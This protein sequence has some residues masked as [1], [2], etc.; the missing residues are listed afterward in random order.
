MELEEMENEKI[1]I[2]KEGKIVDCDVLFT[3]DCDENL[4]SYIADPV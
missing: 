4:K 3:F 1:Q 2:E